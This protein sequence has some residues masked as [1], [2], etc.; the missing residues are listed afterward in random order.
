MK[1]S[2]KFNALLNG[3]R[4]LC[5]ILF[6]LITI[7]Y[8][9]R[10]LGN[11]NYGKVNFGSSIISYFVLFAALGTTAYGIREGA[12]V[13]GDKAKF[14]KFANE[15]FTINIIT[16]MISYVILFVLLLF[17]DK[18]F[19]YRLLIIVQSSIM[20][21]NALGIAWVNN[22][23]EDF[24]YT[25]LRYIGVQVVSLVL[26]FALVKNAE[27]YLLYAGITAF[28]NI[29]G[30]IVNYFYIRKKYVRFRLT[31]K[32]NLKKHLMPIMYLFCNDLAATIYVNSDVTLLTLFKGD[33]ATGIYSISTKV[34]AIVKQFINAVIGVV[35][36]RLSA[37]KGE[38][39]D[40]KYNELLHKLFHAILVLIL[41]ATVGIF[42]LS[43]E[44]IFIL[45]GEEFISGYISLRIL[46]IALGLAVMS[47]LFI[48]SVMIV[49]GLEKY[50]L[51]STVI[52]AVV[53]VALNLV[54]IPWLSLNGAA[55]TT[56]IA[57]FI[58]LVLSVYFSRGKYELNFKMKEIVPCVLSCIGIAIICL[59]VQSLILNPIIILIVAIT[60]SVICYAVV[61]IAMKDEIAY[62]MFKNVVNK[63][64]RQK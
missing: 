48:Y 23:F 59:I 30:N 51:I 50:C 15:I 45:A 12:K 27:D 6:P 52:S 33:E 24:T 44:I 10:I 16:T 9:S 36:P 63:V 46:S 29:G 21:F 34:Y 57:E 41:P 42:M 49:N 37:Y 1:K 22:V 47:F 5:T 61:M 43:K 11:D 62:G 60:L 32:P 38:G 4:Q 58:V 35:L 18:L 13:R 54:F 7:P 28:A 40:D 31:T 55:I 25:T 26:L 53:N 14:E 56:V 17:W 3:I 8:V 2:L 19:D 39:R 20:I 64:I